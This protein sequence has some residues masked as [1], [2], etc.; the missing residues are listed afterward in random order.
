MTFS[1]RLKYERE[2]RGWS[3]AKLAEELGTTPVS[4]S[5]WERGLALPSSHFRGQLYTLF[6][7]DAQKM[8]LLL[9]TNPEHEEPPEQEES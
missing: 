8:D 9:D 4:V 1:Q 3:Q 6:A 7:T 2:L 5:K